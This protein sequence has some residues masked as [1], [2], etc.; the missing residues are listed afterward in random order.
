VEKKSPQ[1][2]IQACLFDNMLQLVDDSGSEPLIGLPQIEVYI[3]YRI[4]AG[5]ESNPKWKALRARVL[6]DGE[7]GTDII[8]PVHCQVDLVIFK[9]VKALSKY[10]NRIVFRYAPELRRKAAAFD[11][12]GRWLGAA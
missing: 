2:M 8:R 11:G 3:D 5:S 7:L 12:H 6:Q 10:T 9:V 1:R 4:D